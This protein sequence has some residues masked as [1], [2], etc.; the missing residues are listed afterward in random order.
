MA[1]V[2]NTDKQILIIHLLVEGVSTRA[3]E[4]ITGVHHD[5]VI[6]LGLRIGQQC[7]LMLD[8]KMMNIESN[9]IQVDEI[10]G[11][12]KKKQKNVNPNEEKVGDA[13]TF[14]A[15]DAESKLVPCFRVGKR[16]AETANAFIGDL[17]ARL[18]NRVQISSDG[19]KAYIEA[20]EKAFG[21]EVDYAQTVKTHPASKKSLTETSPDIAEQNNK[22]TKI[23]KA[24]IIGNPVFGDISTSL[25]E[26][27]NLTMRMHSRRL[28]RLTNAFSKKLEN[29][30]AAMA[31]H[32][33]Y[34]NFVRIGHVLI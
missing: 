4:R 14:V 2:L 19:L 22:E 21:T 17:A 3:I 28:T 26:R 5:T 18:K 30:E 9:K 8:K 31:L 7:H 15:M 34:Y 29:F 16:D 20:V 23:E 33:A 12:I 10:W 25:I 11:F 13:W 32:F 6:K 1:N 27:Q 24:I